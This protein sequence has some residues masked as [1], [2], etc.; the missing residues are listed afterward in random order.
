MSEPSFLEL[1]RSRWQ[2]IA[3]Q[4][5]PETPR[6]QLQTEL[7]R[8]DAELGRRQNRLLLLRKRIEKL[9]H[10]LMVRE[11]GLKQLVALVSKTPKDA[12]L[13]A[14]LQRYERKIE[15]LRKLLEKHERGYAR[16]LARLRQRKQERTELRGCLFSGSLPKPIDEENDLDYPF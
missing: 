4:F 9:H 5:W 15:L 13:T 11:Q 3:R 12:D 8:R 1:F 2:D 16:R 14:R 6:Q 7:A 10:L